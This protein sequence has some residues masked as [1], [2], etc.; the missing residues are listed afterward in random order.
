MAESRV[1]NENKADRQPFRITNYPM[2]YFAAI[3]RKN[4]ANM[5]R[6]LNSLGISPLEWRILA[7]LGERGDQSI[8]E[9]CALAVTDRSKVSRIVNMMVAENLV[10]RSSSNTDRRSAALN[11]SPQGRIKLDEALARAQYV[12]A[13]NLENISEQ[14]QE[15]LMSILRRIKDNVFRTEAY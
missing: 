14:E 5:A 7:I 13:R 1:P 11:L 15:I 8:N 9:I 2:H 10:A 3:Q 12:Y 6:A 4:Y